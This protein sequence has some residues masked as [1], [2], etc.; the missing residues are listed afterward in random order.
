MNLRKVARVTSLLLLFL[1]A[2]LLL[3]MLLGIF[4]GE[5]RTIGAYG[6]SAAASV[7]VAALLRW[8]G[9]GAP[10]VLHRKDAFGVVALTWMCLGVL[11]ALPFVLEGSISNPASAIFEAVSGFTT[12]GATVVADV[13]VLSRATNLWRCLMHWVGGMG[14][15]VLFVAVFPQF[16]VG[17]RHLFKAETTGPI[18]EG[19]RPRIRHTALV[20]WWVYA[21]MTVVCAG[22]LMLAKMPWLD[23]ICHAMSTLGTGGF[24]N[25]SASIG[26][27]KSAAVDWIVFAFML[28]AG[29]NFG[30]YFNAIRGRPLDL[31]RNYEVRFYLAVNA[32]VILVVFFGILPTHATALEALR[33]AAFQTAAV[34]TT[35]G[36]MTEDFDRYPELSRCVL[37]FCMFMGA[38]AGSTAGGIKASRV[39]ALGKLAARELMAVLRPNAVVV[40]RLGGSPMSE[41]VMRQIAVFVTTY[42]LIFAGAS[43]VMTALGLDM[44]SAMSSVIAC[45]SSVG[46]GL[47]LVGPT[48]NYAFIPG[49]GKL[50]L[51]FCMIAGRLEVFALLAVFTPECWKR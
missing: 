17:A 30:L 13:G 42:L 31:L 18:T 9:R 36:L 12:T 26:Y 47:E 10:E 40:S 23:A 32:L 41:T 11:G 48:Q 51:V 21:G 4:D 16:G 19:L 28:L 27:Y 37:F 34:T 49:A 46:P 2:F 50:L 24:S 35:T 1:A 38:C 20:L 29:M 15:V 39:Y 44:I 14:I 43:V 45:L 25:H 5:P 6:G 8:F 33:H 7:A 3:P 22:L